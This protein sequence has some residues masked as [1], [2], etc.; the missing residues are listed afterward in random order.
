MVNVEEPLSTDII[1]RGNDGNE[2]Q[3]FV[4]AIQ[5]IAFAKDK[6]KDH[7]W[8]LRYATTRLSGK[9]LRWHAKLDLSVQQSWHL[10][11]QA[12]LE[13]YPVA[14]EPGGGGIATPVWTATTFSPAP[15]TTALPG[16]DRHLTATPISQ[17]AGAEFVPVRIAQSSDSPSQGG[18]LVPS[19]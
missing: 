3:K 18:K 4:V 10:F 7:N 1:F 6:D 15:S 13:E 12:L 17:S 19:P 16:N 11:V 9:A 2:C 8:M 5:D 14:E